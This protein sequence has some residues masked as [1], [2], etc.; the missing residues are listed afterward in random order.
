MNYRL[1]CMMEHEYQRSLHQEQSLNRRLVD[2]DEIFSL[3]F[4]TQ[5][6]SCIITSFY[7]YHS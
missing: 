3:T 6:Q 1:Q 4:Q 5:L 7:S 2:S